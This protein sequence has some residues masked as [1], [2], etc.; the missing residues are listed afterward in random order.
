MNNQDQDQDQDQDDQNLDRLM[1]GAF[2]AEDLDD[3]GPMPEQLRARVLASWHTMLKEQLQ[4][5]LRAASLVL[6]FRRALL[7]AAL[8][9][10]TT[11]VVCV[12]SDPDDDDEMDVSASVLQSDTPGDIPSNEVAAG[13]LGP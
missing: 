3:P 11:V 7:C 9:M 6:M 8:L 5:R 13:D 1:T 2:R 12:I 4:A 10:A